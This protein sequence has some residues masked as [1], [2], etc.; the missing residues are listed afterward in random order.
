MNISVTIHSA[1]EMK[2]KKEKIII[3]EIYKVSSDLLYHI[4]AR[5]SEMFIY[6]DSLEFGGLSILLDDFLQ[7]PPVKGKPVYPNA[8]DCHNLVCFEYVVDVP[9][10][11]A[12]R[13]YATAR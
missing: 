13:S 8:R 11:R 7:F 12:D 3:D 10:F 1:L 5:L 2:P 4:Q 6:S 9:V